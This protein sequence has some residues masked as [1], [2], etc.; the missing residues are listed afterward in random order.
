[1]NKKFHCCEKGMNLVKKKKKKNRDIDNY[2]MQLILQK[3]Q[4]RTY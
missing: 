3:N 2:A 1:M 4:D